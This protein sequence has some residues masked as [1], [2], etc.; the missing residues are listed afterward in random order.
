MRAVRPLGPPPYKHWFHPDSQSGLTP[1]RGAA[2]GGQARLRL[3][4]VASRA[5]QPAISVT[6]YSGSNGTAAQLARLQVV[7][8]A[9]HREQ[10]GLPEKLEDLHILT[11]AAQWP[12][13]EG[14]AQ[15]MRADL[16][17]LIPARAVQPWTT[18]TTART[19]SQPR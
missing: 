4:A 10:S 17:A 11:A 6:T 2:L 13:G 5:A 15:S 8:M 7:D 18:S 9:L 14:V 19:V 12:Q 3:R 16:L 1:E